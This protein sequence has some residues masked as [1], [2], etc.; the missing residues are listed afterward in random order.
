M[1][2]DND[3]TTGYY[4]LASL[5][6]AMHL[7]LTA[8]PPPRAVICGLLRAGALRPGSVELFRLGAR[9][10]AE[11]RLDHLVVF[12]AASDATGWVTHLVG[13]LEEVSGI[14]QGSV[15]MV[16]SR[17]H[18]S[19]V[20]PGTGHV[21]KDLRRVCGDPGRCCIVDD[22]PHFVHAHGGQVLS[23]QPYEQHV[24]I[25]PLIELIPCEAEGKE[26]ARAALRE[27]AQGNKPPST[28]DYSSDTELLGLLPRI[29]SLFPV[30]VSG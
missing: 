25:E 28:H 26:L 13:C 11:G 22:K 2:L 8:A 16:L 5:L 24:P 9:L 20:H 6:F 15:D 17:R 4:Q 21:V 19:A 14:P 10:K 12:T 7:H 1:I 3:E 29:E 27:D 18:A 30:T 23:V